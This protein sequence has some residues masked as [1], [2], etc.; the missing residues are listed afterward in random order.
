MQDRTTKSERRDNPR[1]TAK[2]LARQL[3]GWITS[4]LAGRVCPECGDALGNGACSSGSCCLNP[5]E[6]QTEA[7][8]RGV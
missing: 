7:P 1:R 5:D 2:R 6:V 3:K 4:A 8:E